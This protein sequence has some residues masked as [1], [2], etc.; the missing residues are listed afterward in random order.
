VV[1]ARMVGMLVGISALTTV[2]LRRFHAALSSGSTPEQA[3]LIQ[4]HAVFLGAAG[5]AAV[6]GILALCLL[7]TRQSMRD[8]SHAS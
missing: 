1:V 4:E 7:G 6:A 8:L 2:G 5:C 3:A